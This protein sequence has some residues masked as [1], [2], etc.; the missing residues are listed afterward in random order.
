MDPQRPVPADAEVVASYDDYLSAQRAVDQLADSRFPVE[1]VSVVGSDLRLVESVTAR[2]SLTRAGLFGL[3]TGV[4]VGFMVGV[5][6]VVAG[7]DTPWSVGELIG[8]SAAWGAI[9]GLVFGL[10]LYSTTRGRRDFLSREQITA[11]R[12]DLMVAAMDAPRARELLG[13]PR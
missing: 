3:G 9:A 7:V 6:L 11:A 8:W 2:F 12:Y 4:W 1:R 13:P 10:A 5:L